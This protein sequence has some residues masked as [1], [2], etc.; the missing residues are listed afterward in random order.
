MIVLQKKSMDLIIVIL[1]VNWCNIYMT[2][3]WR[4]YKVRPIQASNLSLKILFNNKTSKKKCF[5]IF[6]I[7]F[8]TK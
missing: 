2:S 7:L 8:R 3:K 5:A 6:S 4:D 1:S